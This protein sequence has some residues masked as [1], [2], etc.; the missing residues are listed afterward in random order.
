[1]KNN[2]KLI[3][4]SFNN[5]INEQEQTGPELEAELEADLKALKEK[6]KEAEK[7]GPTKEAAK[8]KDDIKKKEAELKRYR[9][10]I[11]SG[12]DNVRN[13]TEKDK[14]YEKELRGED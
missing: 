7:S 4:E 2:M 14:E 11:P 3:M 5:W 9:D 10:S 13:P 8:L 12:G 6:L 1:M